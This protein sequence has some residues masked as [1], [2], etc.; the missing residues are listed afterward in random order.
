[1]IMPRRAPADQPGDDPRAAASVSANGVGSVLRANYVS[2]VDSR[3]S[4]RPDDQDREVRTAAIKALEHLG[5]SE[6]LRL[7]AL[8]PLPE[9]LPSI[10]D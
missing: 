3:G 6:P 1:M 9:S 2:Q 7:A 5:I 10:P 4:D 8:L